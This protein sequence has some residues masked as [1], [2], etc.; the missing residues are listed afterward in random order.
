[1]TN[2]I[3][4]A[5]LTK[6]EA[7]HELARLA[8]EIGKHSALYHTDD[9]PVL[10]DSEYDALVRRNSEIE[11]RFPELI[12]VDTP[13]ERVGSAPS[14]RFAPVKHS[15]PMLSLDNAYKEDDVAGFL[16]QMRRGL[17]ISA[18]QRLCLTHELKLDGLS[19]SLRYENQQLV[20]GATRGDGTTGEDL[21]ANAREVAGIPHQLP[22][23][24]PQVLE[25]RGE[26]IM[27]KAS[28]LALNE[29]GIGNGRVFANPR[30]AA[31]GSFR[32]S[33]PRKT[34][35]RKLSFHVH[36][37]GEW[38]SN[39]PDTWEGVLGQLVK[40]GFSPET[41][42]YTHYTDGSVAEVMEVYQQIENIR[43]SLPF[44]IDGIVHKIDRLKQRE[45]LGNISRTPKWAFAHKFPAEKA[46][47][48]LL[49][50]DIQVGRTGRMTPVARIEPVNVG[51]VVVS[52][53]S[54]H[55]EDHILKLDLRIGDLVTI[56]R[57]GDVIPQI[58]GYATS[59]A[60][61]QTLAA[62]VFPR[63]CPVCQAKTVRDENEADRCCSGGLLCEAQVVERLKHISG[64]DALDIDG[65][66][67]KIIAEFHANGMLNRPADIF[68]LQRH[69]NDLLAREGWGSTSVD[70]LL[71]TIEAARRCSVE[72][73]LYS[74]GIRNVGR[75]ATK[76]LALE[77]GNIEDVR[78][79]I[80]HYRNLRSNSAMPRKR[81]N[82]DLAKKLAIQTIG[83]VI[84]GNLLD[85]FDDVDNRDI[86]DDFFSE[87]QPEAL[88]KVQT[89]KSEVSGKTVVFTGSLET[90]SRDEAKA[91]AERLGAKISGSIS[92]KTDLLV[93]GP[94]AGS[95]LTKA[96]GLG[97]KCINEQDWLA[98]VAKAEK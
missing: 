90:M 31:A 60:E 15:Q 12:R 57:A 94:G 35:E 39:L 41:I 18:E 44:D 53:A 30:N 66:G 3:D 56:Q 70:K 13:S 28:F 49:G 24:A 68:R 42:P 26:V 58:V 65:L 84:I 17:G 86:A 36:G 34:A 93:A 43:S 64:R 71:A 73:A 48:R 11:A 2:A 52:N 85:F 91:Q 21:T 20:L 14:S 63:S 62:Y 22:M 87:L 32:N 92:A 79:K 23:D 50:I 19:L 40:W 29:I 89:V 5:M 46:V 75:S 51:G 27:T 83:G 96:Q 82:E 59:P 74:L 45:R 25:V 6:D 47:A 16:G 9:T 38:S 55:N 95:K 77:W 67:G 10:L 69:R 37:I 72:R 4:T 61:H 7:S 33:D 54:L 88:T 8:T 78:A 97:V 80:D 76:A 1:M 81:A 98:I